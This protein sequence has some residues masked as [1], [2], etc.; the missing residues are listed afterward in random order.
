VTAT[1]VPLTRGADQPLAAPATR[2]GFTQVVGSRW[3]ELCQRHQLSLG[4]RALLME[5]LLAADRRT[6][7][8]G[9]YTQDAWAEALGVHRNSVRKLQRELEQAG[10]IVVAKVPRTCHYSVL[11][12]CWAEVVHTPGAARG[13]TPAH[14]VST[15][16]THPVQAVHIPSA[17]SQGKQT[18]RVREIDRAPDRASS[19]TSSASPSTPL[20]ELALAA[21]SRTNRREAEAWVGRHLGAGCTAEQLQ[22]ALEDARTNGNVRHLSWVDQHLGKYQST[23]VSSHPADR[24]AG[25]VWCNSCWEQRGVAVS[26]ADCGCGAEVLELRSVAS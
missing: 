2:G 1:N 8:V 10:C 23:R 15:P 26:A 6:E 14:I 13:A 7:S 25:P 5:L 24:P 11:I 12:T 16:S 18:H 19:N 9:Y 4:A 20:V 22:L 21:C 3:A 17:R